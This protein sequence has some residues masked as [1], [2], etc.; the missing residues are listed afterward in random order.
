MLAIGIFGVVGYVLFQN[1]LVL[2]EN[3][4]AEMNSQYPEVLFTDKNKTTVKFNKD[5]IIV[6]DFWTT[7]CSIC[8]TKFPDLEQTYLKYKNNPDVLIYAVNVPLR[9]DKFTKTT[10][11]LKK[12]G[13]T[14]PKIYA[15]S[16][17]QV[18]DSLKVN[19]FPHLLILKNGKIRFSGILETD[20]KVFMYTIDSQIEKLLN[21]GKK[22]GKK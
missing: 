1:V 12:L 5:K 9:N 8:F 3:Q 15:A 19:A 14:F 11:I 4:N 20:K 22:L 21:E 17:K 18:E 2:V 16:A 6:L 7:S 10:T 13:Y